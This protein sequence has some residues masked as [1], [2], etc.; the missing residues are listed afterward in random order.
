MSY[1]LILIAMSSRSTNPKNH[2]HNWNL[3]MLCCYKSSAS[4][5][6]TQPNSLA[7]VVRENI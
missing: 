6:M 4:Q 7:V 1:P 3:N 2:L 5:S